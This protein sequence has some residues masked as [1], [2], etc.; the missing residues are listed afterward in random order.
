M[1]Y[2]NNDVFNLLVRARQNRHN[3]EQ[4]LERPEMKTIV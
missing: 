1:R 3:M 4:I 2:T